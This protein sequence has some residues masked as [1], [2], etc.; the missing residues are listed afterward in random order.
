MQQKQ[1]WGLLLAANSEDSRFIIKGIPLVVALSVEL[2]ARRLLFIFCG[3]KY[4]AAMQN[5]RDRAQLC[6][7]MGLD[8]GEELN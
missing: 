4:T 1:T 7:F 6:L 8:R 2:R 3:N 5:T